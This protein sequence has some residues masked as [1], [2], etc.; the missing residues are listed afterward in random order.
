VDLAR[1]I[2][3]GV[4]GTAMP[5]HRLTSDEIWQIVSYLRTLQQ[6]VTPAVGDQ[7]RGEALFFGAANCS[8]CHMVKGRGGRL[9]PE[10]TTVGSA[11]SRA[12]LIE[13]VREPGR[14]LTRNRAFGD[15]TLKYDAVTAVTADG[16]TI[17]GVPMNEDTFTVQ[18]MDT[19]ERVHSLD[20]KTL[21]S[22]RH[23]NR[24]LMPAYGADRLGN[25]DLD[26]VIAYLQS[27]RAPTPVRKRGSSHEDQ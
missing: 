3:E 6:P 1:T 8:S 18:L 21:K 15:L 11:R 16:R 5:P 19:S 27:L 20:K 9:G 2:A 4:P 12:Y 23:E 17:V 13:S 25:A 10:L 24:S 7:A 22:L 26:D 14:Q